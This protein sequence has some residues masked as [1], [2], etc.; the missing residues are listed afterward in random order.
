MRPFLVAATLAILSALVS[1]SG[2]ERPGP[3]LLVGVDG[4]T[5][6]VAEPLMRAGKMPALAALVARGVAAP[7]RSDPP[8][9][10]PAVWTS[11]ATGKRREKH[12]ITFFTMTPPVGGDEVLVNSRFRRAAALWN[13]LTIE[14]RRVNCVGYW[15]TWPP[16][17]VN[18]VMVSDRTARERYA[19]WAK[20]APPGESERA[21]VHPPELAAEIDALVARPDAIDRVELR[22]L[23]DFTDAEIERIAGAGEAVLY[24]GWSVTKFAWQAQKSYAHIGERL[25][26]TRPADLTIVF[27][28]AIDPISHA[29]WHYREPSKFPPG[30][31]D[32]ADARRLGP[33]VDGAYVALDRHLA[34]LVAAAGPDA[35]VVVCSDHGFR[36]SGSVTV[37]YEAQSG[38]HDED[39][40][41][42]AAGPAVRALDAAAARR[43]R[44]TVFDVAPTVLALLGL[45]AGRDMDGRVLE[46]I[47]APD[48]ARRV[49]RP[50]ESWDRRWS[51]AAGTEAAPP[52][53]AD[54]AYLEQLRALGYVR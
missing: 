5:L 49:P 7:L 53:A 51:R 1:C 10:S 9:Y 28:V 2:D 12:G 4:A 6:A 44:A 25:L 34:A 18:G 36:A 23:A 16:E 46:E 47:L 33:I 26:A 31:V 30:S 20:E 52:S 45:P 17:P 50:I 32:P 40:L 19:D 14:G 43:L 3:V 38:E 35:T 54:A 42:V 21:T 41:L 13:V 29:F 27:L 37:P 24:D 48:V 11:I 39:G 8:M 15:A 22:S